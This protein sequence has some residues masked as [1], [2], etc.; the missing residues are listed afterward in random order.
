MHQDLFEFIRNNLRH[1]GFKD[2]R[3]NFK[4]VLQFIDGVIRETKKSINKYKTVNILE[5]SVQSTL[6]WL[7]RHYKSLKKFQSW[8]YGLAQ[9][10]R[11]KRSN[12]YIIIDDTIVE[13]ASKTAYGV[14]KLFD[15][16]TG[17]YVYGNCIVSLMVS[18]LSL[19]LALD[20]KFY[21]SKKSLN[22]ER[23]PEFS[24]KIK[25]ACEFINNLQID[26]T[27]AYVVIDSWY[28]SKEILSAIRKKGLFCVLAFK[29]T[30]KISLFGKEY[31][32]NEVFDKDKLRYFTLNGE[33]YLYDAKILHLTD[34][35]R[36]KVLMIK[37]EKD[38]DFR[39]YLTNKLD[40]KPINML[41]HYM[42]RWNIEQHYR[43]EKQHLG[44]K[45]FFLRTRESTES[46][47]N[48]VQ[49]LFDVMSLYRYEL[50]KEGI[51]KSIET[52]V[53]EYKAEFNKRTRDLRDISI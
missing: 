32:L 33:K 40:M 46:Y 34:W 7:K 13:R 17:Q 18:N 37:K 14:S 53:D 3:V 27:K 30:K 51:T 44:L 47:L 4:I 41:R 2:K 23:T 12:T 38:V 49:W 16:S 28:T 31:H 29:N 8:L 11:D 26:K 19:L 22:R 21:I 25:L 42:E 24:T 6:R 15:H 45:P 43:D 52:I 36:Y 10:N 5:T 39:F 1:F 50:A 48:F 9:N 35:G 20:Q